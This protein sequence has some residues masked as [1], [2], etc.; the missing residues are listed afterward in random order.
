MRSSFLYG[1][2]R[3]PNPTNT[4]Y[5]EQ[6]AQRQQQSVCQVFQEVAE[7]GVFDTVLGN[8]DTLDVHVNLRQCVE[9]ADD[10]YNNGC[11]K[12][13]M[14][15]LKTFFLNQ[16][17]NRTFHDGS[18]GGYCCEEQQEVEQETE[19][20]TAGDCFKY[21]CQCCECEAAAHTGVDACSEYSGDNHE[22]CE[23]SNQS[24]QYANDTGVGNQVIFIRQIGSVCNHDTHTKREREECLTQSNQNSVAVDS[25]EINIQHVFQT[26]VSAGQC[27]GANHQTNQQYKQ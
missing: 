27:A 13:C 24:I 9:Y 6:C 8:P 5:G 23:Q 11:T 21:A 17:C 15:S 14:V 26:C 18:R 12:Q 10:E 7:D 19:Q 2:F 3:A 20:C 4:N 25:R 22:A 1:F 16:E